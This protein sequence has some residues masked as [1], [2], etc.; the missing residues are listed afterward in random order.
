MA[1]ATQ[2]KADPK[3]VAVARAV[4]DAVALDSV[5]LFGSRARGDYRPDSDIDL[6]L[7][8]DAPLSRDDYYKAGDAAYD[9]IEETFGKRGVVGVDLL[10]MSKSKYNQCRGGINHVAAQAARDGVDMNGEKPEYEPDPE[11]F[12]WGDINQRVINTDR[13]LITL[14]GLIESNLPQ[15]AIGFHAQQAIENILKAW[16]SAV[17]LEY[18]NTHDLEELLGI[19]KNV[20]D[21][22]VT[23]AG[24][25]LR[26]LTEYAVKYRYQS[27]ALVMDDPQMLFRLIDDAVAAIYERIKALTG[28]DELP[29][30]TPPE[31]QRGDG[32]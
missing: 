6:M 9:A 12:D 15:E 14:E 24:V 30:Y 13:E 10:L 29:R 16:I 11:S 2:T 32:E 1:L 31:Q 26:W 4:Y 17:G 20:P 21:E 3:A 19:I 7:I 18:I 23:P 27:A 5:I 22:L 25:E 8:H 28:V